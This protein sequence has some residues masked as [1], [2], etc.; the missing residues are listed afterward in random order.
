MKTSYYR[1][2]MFFLVA[3]F[4]LAPLGKALAHGVP[5]IAVQPSIAPAGGQITITGTEME[6]GEKFAI[7]L[8]STTGTIPL[9][10][11][12]A[13]SEGEEAGFVATYTLPVEA[14]PGSYTVRAAT[15]EGEAATA[16]LTV[17]DPSSQA[18]AA[19]AM[20]RE[21]TGELHALDRAKPAGQI[22]GAS[23][24]ALASLVLGIWLVRKPG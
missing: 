19:P 24:I 3:M 4:V 9:G 18:S 14:S 16:D 21:P 17:T 11:A 2:S 12:T 6:S 5:V 8:E 22:A 15:D 7:S 1:I 23:L 20:A 13:M 10:E